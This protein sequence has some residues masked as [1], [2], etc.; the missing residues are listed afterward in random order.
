MKIYL[1]MSIVL[2]TLFITNTTVAQKLSFNDLKYIFQHDLENVNTYLAKREFFFF[3]TEKRDDNYLNS[4]AWS[5]KKHRNV[6]T[7]TE[8]YAFVRKISNNAN[9]GEVAYQLVKDVDNCESIKTFC[10]NVGFKLIKT[11][12]DENK[13]LCFTYSDLKYKIQF[14][15]SETSSGQ[16]SCEIYLSKY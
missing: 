4:T 3:N 1:I 2:P 7:D 8:P 12:T 9:E 10:K 6:S 14:C 13:N 16:I 5:C 15:S 11:E